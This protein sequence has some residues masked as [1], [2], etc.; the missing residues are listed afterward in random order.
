M[1]VKNFL[2]KTLQQCEQWPH[3]GKEKKYVKKESQ[4]DD[5]LKQPAIAPA[6]AFALDEDSE[7]EDDKE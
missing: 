3:F 1:R 6:P 7:D 4:E 2:T 5:V